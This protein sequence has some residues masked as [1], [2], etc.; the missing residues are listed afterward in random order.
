MDTGT[1]IGVAGIVV[2][3]AGVIY[4]VWWTKYQSRRSARSTLHVD[5]LQHFELRPSAYQPDLSNVLKLT[6]SGDR[7][8]N[9]VCL[10]LT[11]RLDGYPDHDDP[12]VRKPPDAGAPTRPRLDFSNLRIL[13]IGTVHN[14]PNLFE[15]PIAKTNADKSL[16][17]NVVRLRANVDARFTIVGTKS[18]ERLPVSATLL[19]GYLKQIDI[20]GGGL[21]E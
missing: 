15:V 2:G 11:L 12:S 19:P 5:L 18:D 4:G 9:L 8:D 20:R 13:S 7:I 14:D 3:V 21:L 6:W 17:L 1:A 10:G 16:F